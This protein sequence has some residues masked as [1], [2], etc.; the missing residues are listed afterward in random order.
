MKIPSDKSPFTVNA[1]ESNFKNDNGQVWYNLPFGFW[2]IYF[3][4]K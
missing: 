4:L 3:L 2:V 1:I